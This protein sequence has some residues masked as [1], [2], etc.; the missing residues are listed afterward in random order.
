VLHYLMVQRALR[1]RPIGVRFLRS[2]MRHA[3]DFARQAY[4]EWTWRPRVI[5]ALTL[6]YLLGAVMHHARQSGA[7]DGSPYW[8]LLE[9]RSTWMPD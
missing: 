7:C 8:R 1:S 3:N 4:P 9:Q 5:G 2:A 6:V